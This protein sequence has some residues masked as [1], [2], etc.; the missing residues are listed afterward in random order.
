[1]KIFSQPPHFY[2]L[3]HPSPPL[4]LLKLTP[5]CV[6]RASCFVAITSD[7]RCTVV[8]VRRPTVL[9]RRLPPSPHPLLPLNC[10]SATLLLCSCGA[11]VS[12]KL[13]E[14][15]AVGAPCLPPPT[16]PPVQKNAVS[17]FFTST[18]PC[19]ICQ[20]LIDSIFYRY[21][22]FSKYRYQYFPY[23]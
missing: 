15:A 17:K 22:Y 3:H 23:R 16:P 7:A 21:Q 9:L 18:Y 5:L 4:S 1:M 8:D 12:G 6:T 11:Q 2:Q 14:A 13:G 10:C 19:S 20:I